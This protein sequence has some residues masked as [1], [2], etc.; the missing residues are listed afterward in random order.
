[1]GGVLFGIHEPGCIWILASKPLQCEYAMGPGFVL[2]KGRQ[3]IS[4]S[5]TDPEL[6]GL[7]ALGWYHSHLRS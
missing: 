1:M 5:A 2:A 4:A 7:Q 6:N 3:L